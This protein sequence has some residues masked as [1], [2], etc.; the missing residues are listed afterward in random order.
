M[1]HL[2]SPTCVY[3]VSEVYIPRLRL[4]CESGR[5]VTHD[6]RETQFACLQY[7]QMSHG[8]PR[9]PRRGQK[10]LSTLSTLYFVGKSASHSFHAVFRQMGRLQLG[11]QTYLRLTPRFL[12]RNPKQRRPRWSLPLGSPVRLDSYAEATTIHSSGT[13]RRGRYQ[14]LGN[15]PRLSRQSSRNGERESQPGTDQIGAA[16]PGS[17]AA[18]AE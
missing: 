6:R 7:L 13:A 12:P 18:T 3:T 2:V 1:C 17:A 9:A 4:L 5:S 14:G 16:V 15:K 11:G 8:T 10:R